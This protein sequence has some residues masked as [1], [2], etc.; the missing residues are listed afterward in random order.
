MSSEAGAAN[1]TDS[2]DVTPAVWVGSG[3]FLQT[4]MAQGMA[5]AAVWLALFLT[6]HQ[7]SFL[8]FITWI[9]N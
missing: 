1:R 7:V 4:K 3:I 6:C 5:G 2:L 8:G 9:L